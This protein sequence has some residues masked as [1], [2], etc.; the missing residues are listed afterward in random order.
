MM[1]KAAN[2]EAAVMV[3]HLQ[4]SYGGM[5]SVGELAGMFPGLISCKDGPSVP[6]MQPSVLGPDTRNGRWGLTSAGEENGS[7]AS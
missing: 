5:P 4:K 2:D 6:R 7:C 1:K 3:G